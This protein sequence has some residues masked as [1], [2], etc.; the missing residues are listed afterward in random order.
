[1]KAIQVLLVDDQPLIREALR[2]YLSQ[3]EGIE[4]VGSAESGSEALDLIQEASPDMVILDVRMPEMDGIETTIKIHNRFP[5]VLILGLSSIADKHRATEML[6]MGAKGYLT[7]ETPPAEIIHAIETI[8]SGSPYISQSIFADEL[9]SGESIE[10]VM[11]R[12]ASQLL[13]PREK[14]VLRALAMGLTNNG[15]AEKLF[16]SPRTIEKHRQNIMQKL[17]L[18][19]GVELVAYAYRVGIIEE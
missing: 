18:Q 4:I 11:E 2:T 19:N 14:D 15:I 3:S 10:Q 6:Q 9:E 13:T 5:E 8:V 7:K 1:M 12:I 17:G 16:V